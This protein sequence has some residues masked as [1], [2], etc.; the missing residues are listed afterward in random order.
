MVD[1]FSGLYGLQKDKGYCEFNGKKYS[2]NTKVA[3]NRAMLSYYNEISDTPANVSLFV[4]MQC[5]YIVDPSAHDHPIQTHRKY[6]WVA[7]Q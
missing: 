3:M 2:Y 7:G 4:V 1:E 5:K 6:V